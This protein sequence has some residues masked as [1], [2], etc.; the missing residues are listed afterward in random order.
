MVFVNQFLAAQT[1]LSDSDFNCPQLAEAA[2][3][4]RIIQVGAPKPCS[5]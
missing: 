1:R 3:S 4:H 5:S 2:K